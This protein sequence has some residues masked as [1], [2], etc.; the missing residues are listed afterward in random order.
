MMEIE[1]TEETHRCLKESTR[2]L[3]RRLPSLARFT[4]AYSSSSSGSE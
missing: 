3:P 4:R 1:F 2:R